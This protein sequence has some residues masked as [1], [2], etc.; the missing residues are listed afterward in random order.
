M[1]ENEVLL[2]TAIFE[3]ARRIAMLD[4]PSRRITAAHAKAAI[5]NYHNVI[6]TM[7]MAGLLPEPQQQHSS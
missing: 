4:G 5:D 6:Q 2:V 7:R 1:K 3:E